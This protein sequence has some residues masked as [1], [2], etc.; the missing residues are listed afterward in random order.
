MA[1]WATVFDSA[2][3][4]ADKV[5]HLQDAAA[6]EASN[7]AYAEAG[8]RMNGISL[9][10]TSAAIDGDVAAIT[11]NVL[12]AGSPAYEDLTGEVVLVDGV[13]MVSREAYCGF[14]ASARTP[15]R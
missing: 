8:E 5:P 6:L 2:A 10:P 1:A 15:C 7:A 3:D 11:Y 14:L 12:F 13:W 4:F 9:E